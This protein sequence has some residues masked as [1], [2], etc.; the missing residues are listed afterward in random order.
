MLKKKWGQHLLVS[1]GVLD[2]LVELA[3]I[4]EEVVVE[5]GPGTGNLTKRLL[6][7]PLKRLYLLE[8]DPEMVEKLKVSLNDPRVVIFQTDATTFDFNT[9][10]EKELKL[11]G[12]LPYNVASLIIENTIYHKHLIYQAF[13]M[14]QKEVAERLIQQKSWLSVFVNTFYQLEYLMSIPPRFFVPPPKVNSAYLKFTRKNFDEIKDLKR[15]K[16]FLV[17][18]FSQKRKML[19]HK[20]PPEILEKASILPQKR[21]EELNLLD[22]ITLYQIWVQ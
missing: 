18:I 12:N 22:F 8:I 4:K 1:S 19:K 16:S 15:Y 11:I 2:R 10:N 13:Y 14:V 6:N 9:L 20:V 5:I 7:T 17:Q 21:V 3:E